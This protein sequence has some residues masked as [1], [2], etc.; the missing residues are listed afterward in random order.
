M[1]KKW[2]LMESGEGAGMQFCGVASLFIIG[3]IAGYS[4]SLNDVTSS[5]KRVQLGKLH[6]SG[7]DNKGGNHKG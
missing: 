2:V 3:M 4:H 7:A 1:L 5:H 6:G